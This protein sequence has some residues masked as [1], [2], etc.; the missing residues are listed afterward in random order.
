MRDQSLG[1]TTSD[2]RVD[3]WN[4]GISGNEMDRLGGGG[5]T[6]YGVSLAVGEVDLSR[7]GAA[8]TADH[9]GPNTQGNYTKLNYSLSRLQRIDSNWAVFGALNGQF[10]DRN[11]DSSEKFLLG[12]ASG[13]RAY[14]SGE[15]SGDEGML[16]NLEVRYDLPLQSRWGNWQFVGFYDKGQ[17][18]RYK[19]VWE[20]QNAFTPG[21]SN[22]YG[23]SGAGV[24]INLSKGDSHAVR[25]A[26]AWKIGDN[27]G[28]SMTG[29]D[30]DGTQDTGRFWLQ[31]LFYLQ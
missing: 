8:L 12:G 3:T 26:Y 15:A 13:V 16:L 31:T 6:Q 10:A 24:G 4:A 2:K 17:V 5:M 11:L 18:A 14:P 1:V 30:S 27:P 9:A 21:Q 7:A 25:F 19:T 23:L 20:G 22:R 28:A 29:R